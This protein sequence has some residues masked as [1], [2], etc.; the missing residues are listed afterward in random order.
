MTMKSGLHV[1]TDSFATLADSRIQRTR[2]HKLVDIVA[3]AI[4]ERNSW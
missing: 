1:L 3:I 4:C 2:W